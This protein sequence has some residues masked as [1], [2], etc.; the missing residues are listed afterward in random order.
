MN[1]GQ[2][3]GLEIDTDSLDHKLTHTNLSQ[4]LFIYSLS[5][6]LDNDVKV[7]LLT[8]NT[9]FIS[10]RS[11]VG[12]HLPKSLVICR[13]CLLFFTLLVMGAG[14]TTMVRGSEREVPDFVT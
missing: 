8:C 9:A 1:R 13:G 11:S 7:I 10:S 3:C 2:V 14:L 4:L 6:L 5:I 12:F